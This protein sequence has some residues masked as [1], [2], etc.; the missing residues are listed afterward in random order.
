VV[1]SSKGFDS[2]YI[3]LGPNTGTKSLGGK[4]P[5]R[6]K[7]ATPCDEAVPIRCTATSIR[8]DN[9]K[10]RDDDLAG[11]AALFG[12]RHVLSSLVIKT[13]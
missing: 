12:R 5:E 3:Y 6:A 10:A 9:P 8:T 11:R 4:Q 7:H 2:L 13:R 1:G